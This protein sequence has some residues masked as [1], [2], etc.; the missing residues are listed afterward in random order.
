M[1]SH[2]RASD[3]YVTFR[4]DEIGLGDVIQFSVLIDPSEIHVLDEG[5]AYHGPCVQ[6]RKQFERLHYLLP[7]IP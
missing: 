7:V 1:Q 4:F 2:A 5:V 6:R 3:E